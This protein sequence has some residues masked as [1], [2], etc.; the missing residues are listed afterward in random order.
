MNNSRKNKDLGDW[1]ESL[2][3]DWMQSKGWLPTHKNFRIFKGEIDRIY[4]FYFYESDTFLFCLAEVKTCLFRTQAELVQLFSEVGIKRFL[5]QRQMQNLYRQGQTLLAKRYEM[6]KRKDRV[7]LRL[8]VVLKFPGEFK[9]SW[10]KDIPSLP[11]IK[12]CHTNN[13]CLLI[14]IEPEFT[15]YQ[16]RKSL[17]EIKI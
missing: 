7:F 2:L 10:L 16:A 6:Q 15:S 12:L 9:Q 14:S 4:S 11:S 3:D 5:K 1:G 13:N 8:F 17:L